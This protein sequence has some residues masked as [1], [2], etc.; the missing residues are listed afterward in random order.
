LQIKKQKVIIYLKIQTSR[1]RQDAEDKLETIDKREEHLLH[2]LQEGDRVRRHLHNRIIQL[3]GN[4]R[5]FVRIRPELD[6]EREKEMRRLEKKAVASRKRKHTE[7]QGCATPFRFPSLIDSASENRDLSKSLV[8]FTEPPKDR[9]GL[10]ERTKKWKFGFDHVFTPEHSQSDVWEATEP[11]VQSTIDGYNV[12]VF[13]YGQTGSGKTFTMLGDHCNEGVIAKSVS[14][15][16]SAKHEIESLSDGATSVQLSVELLEIYNECVR[17]LLAPEGSVETLKIVN[18]DVSGSTLVTTSTK[19]EVMQVL[20]LAQSRR[21]IRATKSNSE[22]SR[23][24]MIFTIYFDVTTANGSSRKG[25][26]HVCDLAGSE[27]LNKSGAN[28]A[29]DSLRETKNINSSLSVL[30]NVIAKLQKGDKNIPFRESKLTLVLQNSLGGN[31]KTLA[32]VCCNPLSSHFHETL[33][34][35]RFADKVNKVDLKAVANF[36][37]A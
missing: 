34:S 4:I 28:V 16:F 14:K 27:R 31:S 33:C 19:E 24:H 29:E 15:L 5:V 1:R 8:E 35:L 18:S 23:S 20:K 11:L 26:L 10:K 36:D 32:I 30:S 6:G 25:K 3:C 37:Y 9:G 2:R 13:A 22:S 7:V 21:C 12:C 17:D